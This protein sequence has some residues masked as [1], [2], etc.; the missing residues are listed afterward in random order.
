MT[1]NKLY[2]L[3]FIACFL[4]FIYLFYSLQYSET[5]DFSVCI[6]KNVTGFA[7]PSC[8]TTRAVELLLQ[9]KVQKSLLMNPF[10][11]LIALIMAIVPFW[12]F[13]DLIFKNETFYI[14]YKKTEE[15]LRIKWLAA[16]LILL[17]L[18]NWIWNIYKKT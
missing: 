17:V 18:L 13:F 11:I 5:T 15:T 9:G 3:L 8:G 7:C 16:I 1:K 12:I 4:G 10:G 2:L 14:Y 6:I